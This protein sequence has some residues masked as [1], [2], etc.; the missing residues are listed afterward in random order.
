MDINARQR[1]HVTKANDGALYILSIRSVAFL[2]FTNTVGM[3]WQRCI[4]SR[5]QIFNRHFP[6]TQS[7]ENYGFWNDITLVSFLL[8]L[9]IVWNINKAVINFLHCTS[10]QDFFLYITP[11]HSSN[12]CVLL[13]QTPQIFIYF[14]RPA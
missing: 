5:L 6:F 10:V 8:G 2:L 1:K 3:Y 11:K 9:V 13:L 14:I 12:S 7:M 4:L